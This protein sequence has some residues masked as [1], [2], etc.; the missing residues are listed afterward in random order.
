MRRFGVA[1]GAHHRDLLPGL[2]FLCFHK[3]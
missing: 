3:N 1:A 2:I